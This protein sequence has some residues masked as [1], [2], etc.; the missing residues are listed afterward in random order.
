[1]LTSLLISLG[2]A[3]GLVALLAGGAVVWSWRQERKAARRL[4][5]RAP[6]ATMPPEPRHQ[7]TDRWNLTP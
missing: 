6:H 2:V 5:E 3:L 1:M 7:N 4:R